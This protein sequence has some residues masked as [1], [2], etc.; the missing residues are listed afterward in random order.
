MVNDWANIPYYSDQD[1]A[2]TSQHPKNQSQ[3]QTSQNQASQQMILNKIKQYN[4]FLKQQN[5]NQRIIPPN[6]N[7]FSTVYTKVIATNK[8]A[9][10]SANIRLGGIY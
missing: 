3:H 5:S 10:K 4:E 8:N 2:I 9:N 7:K 1:D 6:V